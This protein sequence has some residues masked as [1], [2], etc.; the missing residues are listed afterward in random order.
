MRI[1]ERRRRA[2]A[3][4]QAAPI[5]AALDGH[6]EHLIVHTGQHYDDLMSDV[7]FRDLGIPAPE[8]NL[9]VGSGSHGQ[10]TG[11]MLGGSR[12]RG[13][14]RLAPDWVLVYR[15]PNSTVAAAPA[16]EG[17][18][19]GA[20]LEAGLRSFNRRMPEEHNRVLTDHASDLLFAPTRTGDAGSWRVG[21]SC[22]T[23]G[24]RRGW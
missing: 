12:A 16:R 1:L 17:A 14:E 9:G 2:A 23:I 19:P 21:G 15:R 20:H 3:V 22:R 10:Q 6:A 4:R 7:F 18:P 13:L 5:A 24:A 11:R 8:V